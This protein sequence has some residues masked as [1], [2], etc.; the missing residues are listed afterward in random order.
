MIALWTMDANFMTTVS[1]K[2]RQISGYWR[3]AVIRVNI[4]ALMAVVPRIS[5]FYAALRIPPLPLFFA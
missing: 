1:R 2:P 4:G 3:P 5:L